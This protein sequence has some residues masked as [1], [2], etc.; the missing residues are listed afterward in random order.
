MENRLLIYSLTNAVLSKFLIHNF[1]R[2]VYFY[3]KAPA[4]RFDSSEHSIT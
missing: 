3:N 4:K 1:D 2:L